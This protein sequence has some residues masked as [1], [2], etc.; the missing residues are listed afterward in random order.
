MAQQLFRNQNPEPGPDPT[1]EVMRR[2]R[3]LEERYYT[4]ERRTHVLE[5]NMISHHRK[6]SSDIKLLR[7]EINDMKHV[8]AGMQDTV[9]RL[10]NEFSNFARIEDVQAVK[11]YLDYWDPVR[12]V[13][14]NQVEKIIRDVLEEN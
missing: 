9:E 11:K 4:L 6:L 8:I 12:F 14:A 5:Q 13:T 2:T 3:T 7:E 1:V 10:L